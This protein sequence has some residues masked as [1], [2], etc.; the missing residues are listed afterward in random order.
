MQIKIDEEVAKRVLAS[1]MGSSISIDDMAVKKSESNHEIKIYN[2]D[3]LFSISV[4]AAKRA[5]DDCAR[6]V[7][8]VLCSDSASGCASLLYVHP[9]TNTVYDDPRKLDY[10]TLPLAA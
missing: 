4:I 10:T 5:I 2:D 9:I 6:W 8:G 3:I 1:V 7:Y